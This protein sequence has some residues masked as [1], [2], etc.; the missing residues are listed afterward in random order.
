MLVGVIQFPGSNCDQDAVNAFVNNMDTPAQLVWHKDTCFDDY[1][2]IIIPGG[3]SYGDYLRCGA[4]ARF[5]PVM[6]ALSQFAAAGGAIL[7]ICNGF[8]ILCEGGLLPGA[9]IRNDCLEFRCL[10]VP[11]QVADAGPLFNPE[12]I[13]RGHVE[14]PIA[15]GEGNYRIDD[16]GLQ[17]LQQNKQILLRYTG[18]NPNGSIDAIAGIRNEAGNVWGMMP[19][20]ERAV[21]SIHPNTEGLLILR[22]FLALQP[23]KSV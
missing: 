14:I 23:A 2:A 4:I 1:D 17:A 16:A 20:P 13:G 15:H 5:S 22:A 11:R 8:Q 6:E 7:G 19:H 9:L 10:T 21:E 3:F 12:V 18:N